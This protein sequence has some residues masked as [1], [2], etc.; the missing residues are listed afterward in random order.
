ML[1]RT[2]LRT[3]RRLTNLSLVVASLVLLSGLVIFM[4][5]SYA[6]I[7]PFLSTIISTKVFLWIF[8]FINTL[9]ILQKAIKARKMCLA[10]DS[11]GARDSVSFIS[12]YLIILNI[13]LGIISIYFG[14]MFSD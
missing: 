7:N 4:G 6:D 14:M 2:A 10:S 9:L 11:G 8:M 3:I 13:F 5:E 1:T 12:H